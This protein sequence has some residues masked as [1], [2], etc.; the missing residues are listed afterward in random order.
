MKQSIIF[1][2][3]ALLSVAPAVA[4]TTTIQLDP[5]PEMKAWGVAQTVVP[6]IG[7]PGAPTAQIFQVRADVDL[8][9]G[10]MLVVSIELE[11]RDGFR[12]W[13]DIAIMEVQL[14][15]AFMSLNS[16]EDIS[17]AFPVSAILGV[18]VRRDTETCLL[19]T[20]ED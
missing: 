18:K 2:I 9:N 14:G 3:V 16:L 4:G 11:D 19:G 20:F 12:D 7:K 8:P 1:G 10:E 15:T 5:A 17:V 6:A 13:Y